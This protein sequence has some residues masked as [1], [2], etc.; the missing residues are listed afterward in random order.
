MQC[1]RASVGLMTASDD[2][3][4]CSL[5]AVGWSGRRYRG[6][7]CLCPSRNTTL[8]T[9]F[10]WIQWCCSCSKS[11]IPGMSV[12]LSVCLSLGLFPCLYVSCLCFLI[13]LSVN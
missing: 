10:S 4:S 9:C 12:C 6:T 3:I 13:C 11:G 1:K 2:S 5:L 8:Y 7:R